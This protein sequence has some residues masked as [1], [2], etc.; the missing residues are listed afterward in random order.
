MII[1]S[2]IDEQPELYCEGGDHATLVHVS[3]AEF[4]RLNGKAR[5]GSFASLN[6]ARE[7]EPGS[8]RLNPSS[9]SGSRTSRHRPGRTRTSLGRTLFFFNGGTPMAY[10][11][12]TPGHVLKAIED[13]EIEMVDLRFT[14]LPGLWQHFSVPPS[15]LDPDSFEDGFG[16]DGSSIRGFQGSRSATCCW[17][18]IRPRRS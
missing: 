4:A 17:S 2:S 9:G 8:T 1:D 10:T 5:H 3:R 11:C 15:A 16:F 7:P 18:R 14:D 6:Q 13:D 12:E